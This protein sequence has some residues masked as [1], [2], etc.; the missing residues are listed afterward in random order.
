VSS[1]VLERLAWLN[2]RSVKLTRYAVGALFIALLAWHFSGAT[3][4]IL[5]HIEYAGLIPRLEQLAATI[6]DD[7]LVVVE[8]RNGSDVHVLALPL[9]YIYGRNVLV[10]ATTTPDRKMFREFLAWAQERYRRVF[11]FGGGGT[12]LLSQTLSVEALRGERFQIPEYESAWNAYPR[13]VKFKEFDF[14]IH[15]FLRAPLETE[16]FDLDVGL[17]DDVYVRRFHAKEHQADGVTFRWTRDASYV[18]IVGTRPEHQTLTLWISDGGRPA[19]AGPAD[20]E[21][22]LNNVRLGMV[23]AS[24][25]LEPHHLTIPHDLAASIVRSPDAAQLRIMSRTWNPRRLLGTADARD[26]GVMIDR[27]EI[28]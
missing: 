20:V 3:R 23:T 7:D 21:L 6:G 12:E 11:F 10:L 16:E 26:L 4:S 19:A 27:I 13:R 22:F 28:R 15:E 1:N 18:S 25:T 2:N 8:S 14:G 17:A 5:H 9:A 24:H